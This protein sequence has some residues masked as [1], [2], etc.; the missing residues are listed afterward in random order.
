MRLFSIVILFLVACKSQ[1]QTVRSLSMSFYQ[2]VVK[3]LRTQ[4]LKKAEW[5]LQQQPITVTAKTSLRSTGG[6]H[7]FYSEGDYWWPNPAGADSPYVQRD[8]MTNPDNFV[9]HRLAMIRFS[10]IVGAL[11][12]AY[13][14]TG[15]QKYVQHILK[16]VN[17]W[18][19]DA[20]T[21]MNPNL[22]YAQAI[23]G[24]ATG[25]G[26][27]IIDTIHL[28]EVVQGLM[29]LEI[30]PGTN[31]KDV[32]AGTKKWF[33]DY[34]QWLTTHK[35]GKDEMNAENNH[36]TCWVM[37]VGAFAKFTGNTDLM[38]FCR[39]RYKNVLLPQQMAVDGSFPRELRRTKP[40]GYS[41]FN[42]DAMAAI[43]QVLSTPQDNLWNY[44]TADGKSI[45]K[46]IEY[47]YPYIADKSKWPHSKDVM[48][49]ENWPVAQPFLVFG[50]KAYNN[51]E[52]LDTWKWLDHDPQVEE[53]IRNLPVRNPLIWF[54]E[55]K[56]RDEQAID[57]AVSGWWT[58]SMKT[59]QERV[60]WWRDAKFGMFIHWGVYSLPAGEWKGKK[61]SGYAEHLMRKE[62]ITRSD[63]LQLA[64]EFNPINFN[65]EQWILHAKKA[66]M[67]YF[68]ITAKHHDGFAMYDSKVSDFNIKKQTAFKRDP[69]AE[70]SAA[71]KKHGVKFGFYY[72]HAFDWEHPDAPG[73]DWEYNNPGGDK[74]IGG[75]NWYDAHPDWLVKAKKYVDEKAIP[76]IKELLKKYHPDILWFDTPQKLPLSENIRILKAIRETDANVVVNGRLVRNSAANFG[77][78]KN[79]ADRPAEFYP[80]AGDWEAIPTTNESYGYHKFDNSHK[81]VSFFIQLMAKAA[82]KGGNLLMNIGPKGDGAFDNKDI[83]ILED[84]GKW[85]DKYGTSIYGVERGGLPLQSWGVS[86]QK[87]ST[88]YLHVFNWPADGE[89]YI[90]GLPAN[91]NKIYLLNDKNTQLPHTVL[92]KTDM[93]ISVPATAPD[94]SN[95]VIVLECSGK[96]DTDS[97]RYLSPNVDT[98]RLLA[99]DAE[100]HGKGFS[101]GDGKTDRY[102]VEGWTKMD[103]SVSWKFRTATDAKYAVV[104]RFIGNEN[105]NEFDLQLD[106][107]SPFDRMMFDFSEFTFT[108][109]KPVTSEFGPL[110][111]RAGTH[112]LSIKPY[113]INKGELMKLLEV[114]LIQFK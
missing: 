108:G 112:T 15:D 114:Q 16:H 8:G 72:S 1:Q 71:A 17:A 46:G 30:L 3:T 23:K 42:L 102:Y 45:R 95:S 93:Y 21:K 88:I 97:I 6:K 96:I 7:D 110:D 92:N 54:N 58:A 43:C 100:L 49:W 107:I 57:E 38:E 29:S 2:Q 28:I 67:R 25:R 98:H 70:L 69:T 60:Q 64:H 86:T 99:F 83:E 35:Y 62:K 22:L 44:Q 59:H 79:T 52:W 31:D 74:Q 75:L 76:Q 65:A 111:I 27:G 9:A 13:K 104:L 73:N 109:A 26:I 68:I 84:I 90:G 77:D 41:I 34:L 82:A 55:N 85:M 4:V 91:I 61:V 94:A 47:L 5:A 113:I 53:V 63:Y 51:N 40:Y 81:S 48:Y 32:W 103:Q 19:V 24:R 20:E 37:Q 87:G 89:L 56:G 105:K 11:A 14:M 36:G 50:A 33:E 80:V 101:Y 39:E 18:F 12:S 78:Y 66:G 106:G 10:T